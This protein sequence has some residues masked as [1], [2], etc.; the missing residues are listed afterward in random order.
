M[1]TRS[2]KRIRKLVPEENCDDI[3]RISDLPDAI[4]HHILLLLPIKSIAKTSS[5]SKR[6]RSLW[7]SFPDLDFTTVNTTTT[8]TKSSLPIDFVSQV[9][10]LR[11]KHSHLRT[12]R[13]FAHLSFSGLNRLIRSAIRN[14]VQELDVEVATEDYFN[15]PRW[16]ITSQSL[17]ILNI[18]S[19]YPGFRL[20]PSSVM[21][22]GFQSLQTLSL[23]LVILYDQPSLVDLFTESSFLRLKKLKLDA[24]FGLKHLKIGCR[25]LEDVAIEN[26]YQLQSLEISCGRLDRLRVASCFDAYQEK[27]WI[28]LNAPKLKSVI[29]DYNAI[30]GSSFIEKLTSLIEASVG[31]Y[32][33]D[34]DVSV[35]EHRSVC[36]LLCGFSNAHTLTLKSQCV[37]ILSNRKHVLHPF[38]NLKNLEL[39]TAFNKSIVP[40][41]ASLFRSSPALHTLILNI[42]ND[43]KVE[44]RQWNRDLWDLSSTKEEMYWES[45]IHSLEPFLSNL[46][47]VKIDGFLECENEVSLAK[48]L[49]K[50]GKYLQEMTL[51]TA[52]CHYRDSLRRQKVRSQ[53]MG[54]SWASSNAKIAFQ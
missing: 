20:L 18:K 30:T 6:W 34:E 31:F 16:V 7:Y 52:H 24:C 13:F 36:D 53:M 33:V 10:A 44:K 12:L 19:R 37:E 45:Q 8:Q 11:D 47:V 41:L 49:L 40:G 43:Y 27:S 17:R 15:F 28:K 23:T 46:K 39:H 38:K 54:F 9:L 3:D 51:C 22:D 2:T 4:L 48:F 25:A 5:L 29:W 21:I 1:E 32:L 35:E 42:I 26:C 50:H 14:N